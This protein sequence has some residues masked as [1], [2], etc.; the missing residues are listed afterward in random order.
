MVNNDLDGILFKPGK[1][2][3]YEKRFGILAVRKGYMTADELIN[4]LSIQVHEDLN[5]IPHRLLGQILFEGGV[6]TDKQIEEVLSEIF[7]EP[8]KI[9]HSM[10]C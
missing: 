5:R 8:P 9:N 3:H 2:E 6:M 1:I 4:G 7:H 10:R